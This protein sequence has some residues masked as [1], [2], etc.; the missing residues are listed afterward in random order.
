MGMLEDDLTEFP[1]KYEIDDHVPPKKPKAYRAKLDTPARIRS[2]M[3]RIY[4]EQRRGLITLEEA[5]KLNHMLSNMA[6][7][8][9]NGNS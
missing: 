5:S 6:R 9:E 3:A 7:L 4:R 2:E 1:P 8:F